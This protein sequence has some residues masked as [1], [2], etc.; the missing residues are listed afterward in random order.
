MVV[1]H[2]GI[3]RGLKAAVKDSPWPVDPHGSD[4]W[5]TWKM[6]KDADWWSSQEGSWQQGMK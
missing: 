3:K 4:M 6:P 5:G 1:W 2:V